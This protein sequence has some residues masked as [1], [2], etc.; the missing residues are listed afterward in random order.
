MHH[1][2]KRGDAAVRRRWEK[3]LEADRAGAQDNPEDFTRQFV[4]TM[5]GEQ[6]QFVH[7]TTEAVK[8]TTVVAEQQQR[9]Q[10][11][12]PQQQQQQ[13]QQQQPPQRPPPPEPSPPPPALPPKTKIMFSPSRDVF[14][15]TQEVQS[16]GKTASAPSIASR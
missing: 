14:S 9:Q 4:K 11:Q 7:Q 6:Q 5:Y 12:L 2:P 13:Q 8:T 1:A 16:I 10:Q 15:P 3:R